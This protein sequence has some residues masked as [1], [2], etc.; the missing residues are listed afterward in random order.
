[1]A[2]KNLETEREYQKRYREENKNELLADARE[3]SKIYYEEN[4]E[5]KL[6]TQKTVRDM[7][8][9]KFRDRTRKSRLKHSARVMVSDAKNR[10]VRKKVPFE[11][12]NEDVKKLQAVID[13]GVCQISGL[14][15]ATGV[16]F[17][18]P[19]SPSIDR[20]KPEL[21]YVPG[22]VRIVLWAVNVGMATW[23]F[24]EYFAVARAIVDKVSTK[25]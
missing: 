9:E 2:F 6:A 16:R 8:P 4:R 19:R 14:S 15:F 21:G 12:T 10:A 20:I 25:P 11:L 17:R 13:I 22:N 3:R 1:M 5:R 23:G 7:N 18:D 24:D